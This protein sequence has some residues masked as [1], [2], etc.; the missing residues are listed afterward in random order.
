MVSS[1]SL[2]IYYLSVTFASKSLS[3]FPELTTSLPYPHVYVPC[4][5]HNRS[6]IMFNAFISKEVIKRR[7]MTEVCRRDG[8]AW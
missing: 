1:Y 6:P 2:F 4:W 5:P 8:R 3:T 7:Y